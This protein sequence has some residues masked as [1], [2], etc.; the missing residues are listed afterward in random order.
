[1]IE[2]WSNQGLKDNLLEP[3]LGY[4]RS[5]E[6]VRWPRNHVTNATVLRILGFEKWHTFNLKLEVEAFVRFLFWRKIVSGQSFEDSKNLSEIV[7][8]PFHHGEIFD[9]S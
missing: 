2:L 8:K 7:C 5:P 9:Q 6:T 1:M 4:V 3:G